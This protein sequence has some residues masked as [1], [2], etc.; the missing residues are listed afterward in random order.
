MQPI[1]NRQILRQI[2]SAWDNCKETA[3]KLSVEQRQILVNVISSDC[4]D[5]EL[6]RFLFQNQMCGRTSIHSLFNLNPEFDQAFTKRKIALLSGVRSSKDFHF[7]MSRYL[8]GN[9]YCRLRSY[10]YDFWDAYLRG[11]RTNVVRV[12]DNM[13]VDEGIEETTILCYLANAPASYLLTDDGLQARFLE[14]RGK[15]L[16]SCYHSHIASLPSMDFTSLIGALKA[17]DFPGITDALTQLISAK[18]PLKQIALCFLQHAPHFGCRDQTHIQC[19]EEMLWRTGI[20][21]GS[22]TDLVRLFQD[23]V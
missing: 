5:L 21:G 7:V 13:I 18:I 20:Y 23:D 2:Q 10:A 1:S 4:T 8:T 22:L 6:I 19:D 12:L 9:L 3:G 14:Y 17:R 16:F 11:E 15:D